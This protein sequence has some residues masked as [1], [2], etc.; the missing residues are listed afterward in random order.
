M[1]QHDGADAK[2]KL[3]ELLKDVEIAMMATRHSDGTMHSRPM[4]TNHAEFEGHLWFL[5][6]VNSEKV[7]DIYQNDEVMIAYADHEKQHY[8]SVTGRAT[9]VT[10]RITLAQLWTEP[11]RVWF[12]HGVDDPNLVA[13]R[14]DVDHAEY[15]DTHSS[16]MKLVYGYAKALLTGERPDEQGDTGH[17]EF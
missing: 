14:V 5:T 7:A 3:L 1:E 15:W 9:V 13:I 11:S 4:A 12:P 16:R 17:V 6:D 10:D 8:V 2:R